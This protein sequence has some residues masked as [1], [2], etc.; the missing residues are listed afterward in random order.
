MSILL[1]ESWLNVSDL[2]IEISFHFELVLLASLLGKWVRGINEDLLFLL[3]FCYALFLTKLCCRSITMQVGGNSFKRKRR[4]LHVLGI[5]WSEFYLVQVLPGPGFTWSRFYL[6]QVLPSPGFT[7]SRFYLVQVLPGSGFTWSRF[8]MVQVLPGPGFTW[9]R[10][11]LV[12]VLPGPGFTWSRFYLVQVL[13]G[14]GF[15]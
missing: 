10:F 2:S 12:Q 7:W 5:T 13:P 15:T 14:P 4:V 6:V 9:S 11:C 1:F 8:Y 3:C